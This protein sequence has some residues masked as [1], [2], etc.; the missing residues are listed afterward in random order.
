MGMTVAQLSLD[1]IAHEAALKLANRFPTIQFTSGRRSLMDQA[2][3]M[4][5]NVRSNPQWIGQTYLH[6]GALQTFVDR[7]IGDL[8]WEELEQG[9]FEELMQMPNA[10]RLSRHLSGLAF[11]V[12]PLVDHDGLPTAEGRRVMDY[13]RRELYPRTFLTRE[14]GLVRW[15]V[16]FWAEGHA[17]V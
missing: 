7:N 3:I 1:P 15:H 17:D 11:D 14:G 5:V 10:H 8:T 13:I 12:H 6:G 4:T 9:L 16:D 2:R